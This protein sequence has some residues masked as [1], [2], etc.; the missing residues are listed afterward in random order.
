M[1]SQALQN[2]NELYRKTYEKYPLVFRGYSIS[3]H[4]P[5]LK[6]LIE[7]SN[8]VSCLDYGCGRA[9]MWKS[10]LRTELK[11]KKIFLFDP[12]VQEFN[13][14]PDRKCD[15][16]V[17]IDM[18]EHVPEECVDEVLDD[19]RSFATKAVFLSISTRPASKKLINGANAHQTVKP[20]EWWREK[21]QKMDC[22]VIAHFEQ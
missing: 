14:K 9:E 1:T 6:E 5:K 4:V 22:L 3:K 16:V 8:I 21:I 18:L 7:H 11:L 19:I 17:A 13:Q 20:E 10:G 12:G 15:L 2:S